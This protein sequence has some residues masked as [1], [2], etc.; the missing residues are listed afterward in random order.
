MAEWF[1]G[2][3]RLVARWEVFFL[4]FSLSVSYHQHFP[5]YWGKNAHGNSSGAAAVVGKLRA[6]PQE[7]DDFFCMLAVV[8]DI[9][10][11]LSLKNL[12]FPYRL[13]C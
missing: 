1:G 8:F 7:S 4:F 6:K 3:G 9:Y 5:D 10:R 12:Y 2:H 11:M 13:D